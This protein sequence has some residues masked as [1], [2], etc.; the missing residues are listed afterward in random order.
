[1]DR[2]DIW[3]R[4]HA[5]E[6]PDALAVVDV[7]SSRRVTWRELVVLMEELIGA[8]GHLP[9]G[10]CVGFDLPAG[11]RFLAAFGA[12]SQLGLVSA[13]LHRRWHT[14]Q[15]AAALT[16]LCAN[17]CITSERI[18]MLDTPHHRLP[19][20]DGVPFA[21][22]LWTSGSS[23]QPRAVPLTWRNLSTTWAQ[24]TRDLRLHRD[25][26]CAAVAPWYHVAGLHTVT[27]PISRVGG[28]LVCFERFD[29]TALTHAMSAHHVDATFMVP[30]MWQ[31][32]YQSPGFARGDFD[33]FEVALT[34]GA[35]ASRRLLDA[36]LARGVPLHIG[37]GM[38]EAAPMVTLAAPRHWRGDALSVG[39]PHEP[40]EIKLVG[41]EG[42]EEASLIAVRGSNVATGYLGAQ[43]QIE[44]DAW[45][46]DGF[47]VTS[48]VGQ[49]GRDGTLRLLGRVDDMINSGGEKIAPAE[50]EAACVASLDLEHVVVLGLP[51][52]YWGEVV[53]MAWRGE[54]EATWSLDEVRTRLATKI[55]R[56]KLPRAM[57]EV[58]VWPLG[59]TGKVDRRA[60]RD[61]L[62]ESWEPD[63][64][65][66]R[67]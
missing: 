66:R 50:I 62:L 16:T 54:R 1:M 21:M 61:M 67:H 14:T 44:R 22:V 46:E 26:V 28:T 25:L 8:L 40:V 17:A 41:I 63:E 27:L 33:R 58:E 38:T 24:F 20:R 64:E 4:E 9:R 53:V 55:A 65:R 35:R 57:I 59:A 34:G 47:F 7:A 11:A 43:G 10:G 18:I 49:W 37:Y 39:V 5:N 32:L 15:R 29:V 42:H 51:D 48:D 56:Y 30:T 52:T 6:R 19:Q 23:G 60:L 36:W 45:D 2:P 31:A 3:I 13:P 12:C